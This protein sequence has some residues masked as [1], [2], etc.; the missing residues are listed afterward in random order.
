[1]EEFVLRGA[2]CRMEGA[3]CRSV[4]AGWEIVLPGGGSFQQL[5]KSSSP[6]EGVFRWSGSR[7]PWWREFSAGREVVLP[8]GGSFA[9]VGKS[10]SPGEEFFCKQERMNSLLLNTN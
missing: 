4:S 1:M 10:S 5:G 6:E 8:G 2:G 9:Q 7:P 3:G